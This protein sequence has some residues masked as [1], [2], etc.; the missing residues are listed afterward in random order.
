MF[1]TLQCAIR[2]GKGHDESKDHE[3]IILPRRTQVGSN[4]CHEW[5]PANVEEELIFSEYEEVV[6]P[7]WAQSLE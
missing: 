3:A 2:V 1:S 5:S 4:H 6:A 7:G